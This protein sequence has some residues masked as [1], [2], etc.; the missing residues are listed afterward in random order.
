MADKLALVTAAN[1]DPELARV[2][3]TAEAIGELTGGSSDA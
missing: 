2:T 1:L 3:S